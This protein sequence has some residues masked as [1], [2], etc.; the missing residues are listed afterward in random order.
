MVVLWSKFNKIVRDFFN[1]ST[2]ETTKFEVEFSSRSIPESKAPDNGSLSRSL[3]K[4]DPLVCLW[5]L[6]EK[7]S[8]QKLAKKKIDM[9]CP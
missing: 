2:F 3:F 1:Y 8:T 9:I 5:P 4:S 6:K 7:K